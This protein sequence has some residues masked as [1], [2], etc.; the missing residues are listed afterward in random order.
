MI[1]IALFKNE[2]ARISTHYIMIQ[3]IPKALCSYGNNPVGGLGPTEF[4]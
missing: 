4:S 2:D 1:I 3:S